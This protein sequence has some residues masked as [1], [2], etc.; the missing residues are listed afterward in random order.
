MRSRA[1]A[2]AAIRIAASALVLAAT[3]CGHMPSMSS[4]KWPW[5]Q[6][7]TPAPAPVHVLDITAAGAAAPYPQSFERN[8]LLVDLSGVSGSG[9]LTL[10]PAAGNPWPVRLAFK[11]TPGAVGLVEVHAEQRVVLPITS[12]ASAPIELELAP[13]VY[14]AATPQMT[15]SWGPL[16]P[17]PTADQSVPMR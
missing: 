17:P 10:K 16:P 14:T 5:A 8:T 4:I 15:V 2:Q 3:A 6:T 1:A 11:I 9:S 13:G 12:T 7:P